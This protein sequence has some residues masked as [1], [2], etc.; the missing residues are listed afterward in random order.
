MMGFQSELTPE[1]G[2]RDMLRVASDTRAHLNTPSFCAQSS[3]DDPRCPQD[4]E[5]RL[6]R[7]PYYEVVVHGQAAAD[8]EHRVPWCC[9]KARETGGDAVVFVEDMLGEH[10]LLRV[11]G[12]GHHGSQGCLIRPR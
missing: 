2:I 8:L 11:G 5:E 1:R 10:C 4:R 9:R 7:G 6:G 3:G 12:L